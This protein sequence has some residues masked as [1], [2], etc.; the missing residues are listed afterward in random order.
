[1]IFTK[2]P[3]LDLKKFF[4]TFNFFMLLMLHRPQ[5]AVRILRA[6]PYTSSLVSVFD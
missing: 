1:M 3:K 4:L 6:P 5:N 2:Y